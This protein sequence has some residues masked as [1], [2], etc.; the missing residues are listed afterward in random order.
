M[1]VSCP[2][3]LIVRNM[4]INGVMPLPALTKRIFGGGGSGSAKSPLAAANR[5][6][7]PGFTPLTR[8]VERKPSGVAFTVIVMRFS[9]RWGTEVRE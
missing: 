5:T 8:C 2:R 4:A 7:V 3:A 1:F 9:S 6:I